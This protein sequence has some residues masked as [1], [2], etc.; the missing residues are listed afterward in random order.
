MLQSEKFKEAFELH[1]SGKLTPA[2]D[3][4]LEILK[5]EPGNAQV[6]DVLGVLYYQANEYL[7]A[8]HCIK[9]AIEISPMPI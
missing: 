8:E 4:Y 6:W 3:L 5:V 7:D 9:K 1:N 2:R